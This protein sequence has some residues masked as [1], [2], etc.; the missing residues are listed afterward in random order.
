MRDHAFKL[1]IA[2]K[3]LLTCGYRVDNANDMGLATGEQLFEGKLEL[4]KADLY[5]IDLLGPAHYARRLHERSGGAP[6]PTDLLEWQ[7]EGLGLHVELQA[8]G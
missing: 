7:R 8:D 1:C 2:P 5:D 3:A 6:L 4:A